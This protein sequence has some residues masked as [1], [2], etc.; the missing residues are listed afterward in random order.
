[1]PSY[2]IVGASRGLGTWLQYLSRN[3]ENTIIG[4][5]RNPSAV[6]ERL[7]TDGISKVHILPGDMASHKS[8]VAAAELAAPLLPNSLDV[9]IVNG[10]YANDAVSF[11]PPTGFSSATQASILHDD[12]HASLDVNVLGVVYS[13]NALLPLI[14]NGTGKKVVVISTGLDDPGRA[15]PI[16]GYDGN[17]MMITYS[18][19]KAALN[20]VVAKYAADLKPL[21]VMTLALSPGVVNTRERQLSEEHG[22]TAMAML[23]GFKKRAPH[24]KGP[25]TPV[26]SVELQN[27]VIDGLTVEDSGKF[28]SHWGNKEWL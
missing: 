8:L 2:M 19:M 24:W 27:K 11:L 26:E 16:E 25:L 1:M 13:I 14:N 5:A 7:S 9:L 4:L 17:P 12:M 18:A 22:K 21:G 20:M 15:I 3:P 23:E 6:R 28:L 10:A